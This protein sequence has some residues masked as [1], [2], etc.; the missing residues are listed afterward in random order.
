MKWIINLSVFFFVFLDLYKCYKS[1]RG[2][3]KES[4]SWN[5]FCIFPNSLGSSLTFI[6]DEVLLQC[7]K[8]L[9]KCYIFNAWRAFFLFKWQFNVCFTTHIFNII[10]HQTCTVYSVLKMYLKMLH[11][12]PFS[13]HAIDFSFIA[14]T[15][16]SKYIV[17][18]QNLH[19]QMLF[20][21][22]NIFF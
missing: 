10:K 9:G 15:F 2:C 12:M 8:Y 16:S 11:S 13:I 5:V 1:Y 20:F 17:Q 19:H 21:Q 4:E 7:P 6:N 22:R 18:F 14:Q 3:T